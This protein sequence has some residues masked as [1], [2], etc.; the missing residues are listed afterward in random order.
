MA[1]RSLYHYFQSDHFHKVMH[2]H[3]HERLNFQKRSAHF[4]ISSIERGR[5]EILLSVWP[6][7][8]SGG[9]HSVGPAESRPR[10]LQYPERILIEY[11]AGSG[12]GV[13]IW[14]ILEAADTK[15]ARGL[16]F[17]LSRR[18]KWNRQAVDQLRL[19]GLKGT[20]GGYHKGEGVWRRTPQPPILY[21]S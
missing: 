14:G 3:G 17:F 1:N 18:S 7:G 20:T 19:G 9:W 12:Y 2:K 10:L 16:V 15:P 8:L 21:Q 4:V 6:R 11:L 13:S 5:E